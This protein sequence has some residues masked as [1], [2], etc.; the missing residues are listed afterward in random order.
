METKLWLY[1]GLAVASTVVAKAREAVS[2]GVSLWQWM[3]TK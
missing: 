3:R 1:M 2:E